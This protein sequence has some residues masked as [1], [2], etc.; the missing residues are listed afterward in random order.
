MAR[1]KPR[2][3]PVTRATRPSSRPMRASS[4]L[5]SPRD[6][7][8]GCTAWAKEVSRH[9]R[10][11]RCSH[12]RATRAGAVPR[13]A[14]GSPDRIS[15]R[16]PGALGR[17]PPSGRPSKSCAIYADEEV[18]DFG[19]RLRVVLEGGDSFKPI[20]PER[21]VVERRYLEDDGPRALA[22]F[23]ERRVASL[24]FARRDRA[25]AT[26][27]KSRASPDRR[28]FRARHPRRLGRARSPAPD[29]AGRDAGA[30][31][32]HALGASTRGVRRHN[33]IRGRLTPRGGRGWVHGTSS[34]NA[35][36][37]TRRADSPASRSRRPR[38][39][40]RSPA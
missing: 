26:H 34:R 24:R 14:R 8:E 28:A 16:R 4:R 9:A 17:R 13:G 21:W 1:P 35:T 37:R 31:L 12:Q 23:S 36:S 3:A 7:C 2:P 32:G 6:Q 25:R 10:S 5:F 20:D 15:I 30:R 22:A 19:A 29:A 33:P 11:P 18:E 38:A 39:A 27:H 40:A